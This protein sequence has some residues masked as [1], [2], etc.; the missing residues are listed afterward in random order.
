VSPLQRI[1]MGLV[2]VIGNA[3]FPAHPHPSWRAYDGLADPIGW[4]LVLAGLA[5]LMKLGL[6]LALTRFAAI[7]ATLISIPLWVPDLRHHLDASG[8]WAL[9]LPQTLFCFLLAKELAEQAATNHPDPYIAKRFGPLMWA[10]V[11]VAAAPAVVIGG[12][13]HQ[14]DSETLAF[15]IAVGLAFVY[16][17]F[18]VHRRTWLGGPGP[19]LVGRP[20]EEE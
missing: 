12:S 19:L 18:R 9:S 8:E 20:A 15:A 7:T 5:P 10:F 11:V 2:I 4:L 16:F 3:Y 14:F 6:D 13:L 1:A 17:L